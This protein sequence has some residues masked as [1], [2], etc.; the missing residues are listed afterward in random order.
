[1]SSIF[2]SNEQERDRLLDETS[3]PSPKEEVSQNP[4]NSTSDIAQTSVVGSANMFRPATFCH[5]SLCDRQRCSKNDFVG[6]VG[7]AR[8]DAESPPSD[9]RRVA[10]A[11]TQVASYK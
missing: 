7:A 4:T 11:R 10:K 2:A 3:Q 5:L 6:V 1:M 9:F 8:V